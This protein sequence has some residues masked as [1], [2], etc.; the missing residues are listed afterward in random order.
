MMTSDRSLRTYG[1]LLRKGVL[2]EGELVCALDSAM[3][4]GLEPERVLI[5]E[6][7][8]PRRTLLEAL[9][10]YFRRPGV[11]Y[12]ERLPVPVELLERLDPE[13][14]SLSR[15]FP[16]TM[17]GD[18]VVIAACDPQD[19][20][21]REQAE[22]FFEGRDMEF[23][24]AL[25]E[26]I[27]WFIQDFLN[28]RPGLIIGTERTGL[29]FW[30]N[31]MAQWRTR[32]ACYRTDLATARTALAIFRWGLGLIGLST[33]LILLAEKIP[34]AASVHWA[35][36]AGGVVLS[37]LGLARY[38]KVRR[39]RMSPP[40]HQTLME[41]TAA[42]VQFAENYHVEGAAA[43]GEIKKTMLSRL[44]DFIPPYCTFIYPVP[45]SR[46]RTQL[47]RERNMLAAQR[48]V[49][50]CYRT[51]YARARTGLAFI[52]SGVA[53]FSVGMGLMKY[54]GYRPL[55]WLNLILAVSGLLMTVDGLMWYLPARKEQ[56]DITRG[57]Q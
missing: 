35:M 39:S 36:M 14:L 41:V 6:Y 30:R 43:P 4:R 8:V 2:T 50:A 25:E 23:R 18:T 48:T 16:V 42:T 55:S 3:A 46:V 20:E 10:E 28:A 13:M 12:D 40:E 33:A 44:Q 57:G 51:V 32:L 56:A 38:L 31:N 15:W 54:F 37:A 17:E 21:V 1:P 24:V 53:F 49:A 47:A 29:A 27:Q 9:S 7:G 52:R 34:L 11:E 45:A 26:D 19:P 5:R 22:R